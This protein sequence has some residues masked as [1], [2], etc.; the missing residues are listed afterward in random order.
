MT[1]YT[2][3]DIALSYASDDKEIVDSVYHYLRGSGLTVFYAPE[4]QNVLVGEHQEEIFYRIFASEARHAVLF[5]SRHYISKPV[6]MK[7]AR[8]CIANRQGAQLIPV[9]LDGTPLVELDPS[10]NYYRSQNAENIAAMIIS[11]VKIPQT[12]K[13][14]ESKQPN[15]SGFSNKSINITGSNPT[16]EVADTITHIHNR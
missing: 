12:A 11:R 15:Y 10:I 4:C 9:Y 13:L 3:Y 16:I 2:S 1:P 6:P 8:I 5:V 7:E 14:E